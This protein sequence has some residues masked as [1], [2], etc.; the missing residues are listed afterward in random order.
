M[1]IFSLD[2]FVLD[3]NKKS[4]SV[5]SWN[6]G[7]SSAAFQGLLSQI[8]IL[9]HDKYVKTEAVAEAENQMEIVSVIA[10]DF[11]HDGYLDLLVSQRDGI[12][13]DLLHHRLF[14]RDGNTLSK[15]G[16]FEPSFSSSI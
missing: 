14:I 10:G 6:S 3:E 5:Y 9:E 12:N 2:V 16:Q 15:W 7:N 8:Q 4:V 13:E 1:H 11:N